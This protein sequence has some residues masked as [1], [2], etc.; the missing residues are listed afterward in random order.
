VGQL[1]DDPSRFEAMALETI[2]TTR[3]HIHYATSLFLKASIAYAMSYSLEAVQLRLE[4]ELAD[5]ER[6]LVEI[7]SHVGAGIE[8][9]V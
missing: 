8:T 3:L 2:W 1:Q 9:N 5:V 7:G 4:K 6:E